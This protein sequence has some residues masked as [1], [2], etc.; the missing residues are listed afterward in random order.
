MPL[1]NCKTQH[2]EKAMDCSYKF[3][4][5]EYISQDSDLGCFISLGKHFGNEMFS[6]W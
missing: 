3:C 6:P 2:F 1:A 4:T 5:F